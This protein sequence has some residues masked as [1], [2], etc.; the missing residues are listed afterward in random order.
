MGCQAERTPA[1]WFQQAARWYV[2]GHQGCI[3]CGGQYCVFQ[4]EWGARVEYYCS[5][6]EFS[7]CHD[8]KTGNF[9]A[10]P[11]NEHRG[12]VPLADGLALASVKPV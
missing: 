11:G 10:S 4:S 7:A 1:E 2:E 3:W 12:P 9:F 5:H 8:H 6:C